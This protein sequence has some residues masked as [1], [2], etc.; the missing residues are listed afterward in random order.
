MQDCDGGAQTAWH[1][2]RDTA[3]TQPLKYHSNLVNISLKGKIEVASG[4]VQTMR[5]LSDPCPST[6]GEICFDN[7]SHLS[8]A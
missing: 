1:L 6:R 4:C 3:Q 7:P 2:H 8:W 5:Y